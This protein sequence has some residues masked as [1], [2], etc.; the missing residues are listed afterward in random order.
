MIVWFHFLLTSPQTLHPRHV[1]SASIVKQHLRRTCFSTCSLSNLAFFP[2][3][4]AFYRSGLQE[5]LRYLNISKSLYV[6]I[7]GCTWW[8]R[9]DSRPSPSD[10]GSHV[11]ASVRWG[12]VHS[13]AP[14]C[15]IQPSEDSRNTPHARR[16]YMTSQ[17]PLPH[18]SHVIL[19][20][21]C[22][23]AD[24]NVRGGLDEVTPLHLACRYDSGGVTSIL[25]TKGADVNARDLKGRTP[26]HYATRRGHH[27]VSKVCCEVVRFVWRCLSI[28]LFLF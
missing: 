20:V 3:V 16:Q 10:V 24:V 19:P 7:A 2:V 22:F 13:F 15:T 26:L 25:L 8:A 28:W 23:S 18:P 4:V 6:I 5:Q 17:T 9:G 1:T 27:T 14:Q 12:W 11:F 21:S